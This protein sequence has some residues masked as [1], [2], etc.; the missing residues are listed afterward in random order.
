MTARHPQTLPVDYP[1]LNPAIWHKVNRLLLRKALS[2]F[3]HESLLQPVPTAPGQFMVQSDDGRVSYHFAAEQLPLNHWSIP[4]DSIRKVCDGVAQALD[5]LQFMIELRQTLRL[6]DKVMPVYLDEIS[7]TL[8]GSAFKHHRTAPAAAE[9]L[10]A[11][12]QSALCT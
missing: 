5:A 3:A 7:A 8:Y 1:H 10:H 4:A 11:D 6:S 2:E 9:L 12:F